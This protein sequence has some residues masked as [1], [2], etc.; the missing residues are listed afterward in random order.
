MGNSDRRA[1]Q[2]PWS[3]WMT[4]ERKVCPY[5]S[6]CPMFAM[7]KLAG[8]LRVWQDNYCYADFT[9]CERFQRS[10][11]GQRVPRELMPNGRM[12]SGV[13]PAPTKER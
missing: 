4:T 6:T 1:L 12:L 3:L 11:L 13:I 9:R 5:E 2:L 10:Q 7:F 8:T